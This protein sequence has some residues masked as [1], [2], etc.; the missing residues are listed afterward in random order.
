MENELRPRIRQLMTAR[1]RLFPDRHRSR[2]HKV[3]M[4]IRIR[5]VII[6]AVDYTVF[7]RGPAN[8]CRATTAQCQSGTNQ[9]QLSFHKIS[10]LATSSKCA[11]SSQASMEPSPAKGLG[12]AS[13]ELLKPESRRGE[14][15][16]APYFSDKGSSL[17]R[18][19]APPKRQRTSTASPWRC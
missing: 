13:T 9:N 1:R 4:R 7:V 16:R 2:A 19:G 17:G 6:G 11:E 10:S 3:T 5:A 12:S 18:D 8:V 14:F 15:R